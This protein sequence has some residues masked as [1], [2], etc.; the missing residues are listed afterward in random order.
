ME[1]VSIN[2]TPEQIGVATFVD[3]AAECAQ[4]EATTTNHYSLADT[5][6]VQSIKEYLARPRLFNS[7]SLTAGAGNFFNSDVRTAQSIRN[8]LTGAQ[9]DR[10]KGAVGIRATLKFTLVVAA[11]PFHQGIVTLSWQYG[12]DSVGYP[13]NLRSA[14]LP[15]TAHVPHVRLDVA[16]ATMVSLEIP[17]V[18]HTEYFPIDI[19]SDVNLYYGT[20][21]LTK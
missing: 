3:E 5:A 19:N 9:W 2:G 8:L 15:L 16:E 18:S 17:Y 13:N 11:T 6:E 10:L 7:G 1:G 14:F 21:S 12:V 4:I 20:V